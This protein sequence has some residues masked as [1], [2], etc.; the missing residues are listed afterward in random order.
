MA[1]GK[2]SD[3]TLKGGRSTNGDKR[4]TQTIAVYRDIAKMCAAVARDEGLSVAELT[5]PLLRGPL[6]QKYKRILEREL[7]GMGPEA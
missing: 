7:R 3:D 4:E 5:E 2:R 1:K 6:G